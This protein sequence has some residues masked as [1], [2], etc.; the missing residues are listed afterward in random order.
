MIGA[1]SF[2]PY[3]DASIALAFD[4]RPSISVKNWR[5]E[6]V[7]ISEALV[8][9]Q[10]SAGICLEKRRARRREEGALGHVVA[11]AQVEAPGKCAVA[12]CRGGRRYGQSLAKEPMRCIDGRLDG[13]LG[14]KKRRTGAGRRDRAG[15][16]QRRRPAP[17]VND[18]RLQPPFLFR[19]RRDMEAMIDGPMDRKPSDKVTNPTATDRPALDGSGVRS[20][21]DSKAGRLRIAD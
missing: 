4:L 14:E 17:V 10:S 8:K 13:A 15:A 12:A 5:R 16:R 7:V 11:L 9:R 21:D 1:T 19:R 18:R 6:T 2:N 20:M 3:I